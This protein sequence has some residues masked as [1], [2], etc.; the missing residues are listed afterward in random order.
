MP[1]PNRSRSQSQS[2]RRSANRAGAWAARAAAAAVD[3][4]VDATV[5]A[6]AVGE[7]V[8]ADAAVESSATNVAAALQSLGR[9]A[10]SWRHLA[11]AGNSCGYACSRVF[12]WQPRPALQRAWH[13]PRSR[14]MHSPM[15]MATR[16]LNDD[17]AQPVAN[18]A[19]T[20][21]AV[22]GGEV[23]DAP[24]AVVVVVGW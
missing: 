10:G 4:A 13:V 20:V 17:A 24:V 3:A 14:Q 18:A 16:R 2:Q 6:V 1:M 21:A 9:C 15:A 19:A 12:V 5:S 23:A 8:A 22:V 7:D 11:A